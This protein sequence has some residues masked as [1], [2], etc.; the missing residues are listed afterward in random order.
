MKLPPASLVAL[1]RLLRRDG[2]SFFGKCARHAFSG[3]AWLWLLHGGRP[4]IA[5]ERDVAL[6]RSSGL[7]DGDWYLRNHPDVVRSGLDPAGHYVLYGAEPNRNP[8]PDFVGDEYLAL[9]P[10]VR[11][12]GLNPLLHFERYGRES[13]R[14][15]SF[16]QETPVVFPEGTVEG[17]WD[18]GEGGG[19][20][21]TG[22]TAVFA[23]FSRNGRVKDATLFY[24]R[25][26]REVVDRI[27]FVSNNPV[28]PEEA[29]KLRGL[30]CFA[31]FRHHGGYDFFSYRQGWE[32]AGER[33][34]LDPESCAGFVLANDS[35]VG[36]VFPFSR[37]FAEMDRR[38]CD[39]WGMTA[40]A[41]Y[42]GTEHV[43]S[44]FFHFGRRVLESGALGR[45]LTG[46]EPDGDRG[47]VI[48]HCEARL[49]GMLAESGL[50]WDVLVPRSF[51]EERGTVPTRRPLELMKAFGTPLV[52]IRALNGDMVDVRD[53]VLE[54][55][56]AENPGL[57]AVI[58]PA[59]PRPDYGL[60]RRLREGHLASFPDKIAAVRRNRVERGLSVRVLFLVSSAS[61][62]P[63]RPLFEAMLRDSG[64]DARLFIVPDLRWPNRDQERARR[65]CR[66]E[67]GAAFPAGLFLE[68]VPD[69]S[70]VWPDVI[71]GF[72]ADVVCYPSPYDLSSFRYNPHWAVGRPFLPI[73]VNY[74]FYRSVYDRGVLSQQNYAYFWKA[75]FECEATAK[76]YAE[77]SILK[78][79][80]AEVVGY[81]KMDALATAKPWPRNGNRKRVLIAPH[82]SVEGGANDTLA[83]SNFRRYADYFLSLPER[84]P[85]LDFVFRPHPFLF[86]V[87]SSPSQWGAKKTA[88]WIT[89]MKA[90]PNVRWSDE[91]DYFPAFAS[92]DAIVQDCGSYL[93]E[94]FYTGKPCCYMLKE[95]ADIDEKFAPLG[96]ECLSHCY[97]AYEEAAIESF[98]RDV[99]EGGADPKAAARDEFRK[100]IMVNH[101]RAADAALVSIK[102][103]LGMG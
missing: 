41:G 95:P 31:R 13:N 42:V 71:G 60:P 77:R 84:H 18:F 96:K 56:R 89:R 98:L 19:G 99:V 49:T 66:E 6:I 28:F 38:A 61:M 64:F 9:N 29:E 14:L 83:L 78:G 81:V 24:L 3:D 82:H 102:R 101:P 57:A 47:S 63:A 8:G 36:P 88:R 27:V 43:Q 94:W 5:D 59:A 90:R 7:F 68:A 93:V 16:L 76:E 74:G 80:N 50:S 100:R 97:L 2:W 37:C 58:P 70:G 103:A 23:A 39:F 35:C 44:Y 79:A 53:S 67:L 55:I 34:W 51:A 40:Y 32:I 46:V 91:G 22:R 85:E 72:G 26:L 1:V 62:F 75:F 33:G 25:G 30:V 4:Y 11:K 10:D 45:F 20:P 12:T 48:L 52:K 87:L 69:A 73:H 21:R 65:V 15:V 86:T 17:D 92:C 54:Y